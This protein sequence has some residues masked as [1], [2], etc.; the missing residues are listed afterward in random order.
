MTF[1]QLKKKENSLTVALN[2]KEN[3]GKH[4]ICKN[5]GALNLFNDVAQY[6]KFSE[7]NK[8]KQNIKVSFMHF[9]LAMKHFLLKNINI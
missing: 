6:C 9:L 8:N 5:E 1:F 7:E 4:Q 3:S 2:N